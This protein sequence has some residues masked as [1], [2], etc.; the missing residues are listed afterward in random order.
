MFVKTA[1]DKNINQLLASEKPVLLKLGATWCGPCK[2]IKPVLESL[3]EDRKETLLVYDMDIDDSPEASQ[4]FH[5]MGVPTVILF[6]NGREVSRK[7]GNMSRPILE[8]WID[9]ELKK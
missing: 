1:N 3:A 4:S 6:S 5:I 2:T 7:S 9:S 8:D